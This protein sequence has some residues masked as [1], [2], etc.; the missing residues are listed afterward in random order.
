MK[1]GEEGSIQMKVASHF[2]KQPMRGGSTLDKG[3]RVV[4]V[5]FKRK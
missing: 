5:E 1:I 2:V 3:K 4:D